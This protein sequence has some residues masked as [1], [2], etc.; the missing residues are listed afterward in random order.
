M[1]V[2]GLGFGSPAVLA[3]QKDIPAP[4]H[5]FVLPE[6]VFLPD[7]P[8]CGCG[9]AGAQV[10]ARAVRIALVFR[11]HWQFDPV[12]LLQAFLQQPG[13]VAVEFLQVD[14]AAFREYD[15]VLG[16]SGVNDQQLLV[17]GG[18]RAKRCRQQYCQ[19]EQRSAEISVLHGCFSDGLREKARLRIMYRPEC[20]CATGC[21]GEL[22]AVRPRRGGIPGGR[23]AGPGHNTLAS[24][25]FFAAGRLSLSAS[26]IY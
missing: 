6:S 16:A 20:G 3:Q 4:D 11:Q 26:G 13:G 10:D 17:I 22:R 21:P 24:A 15:L 23:P 25:G 5:D 14:V 1:V 2:P 9:F 18:G 7:E 8:G 19:Q 12:S